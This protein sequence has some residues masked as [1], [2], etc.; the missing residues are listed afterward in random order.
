MSMKRHIAQF[1]LSLAIVL[2][3]SGSLV[4]LQPVGVYALDANQQAVCDAIGTGA[5]CNKGT[6][7]AN[8]LN[9]VIDT[10]INV[11]SVLVGVL[12]VI[13]VI[14]AGFK[15]VTSAEDSSK[16]TSAKNTLVYAIVGLVI[17]AL[18]QTIVKFVL[19]KVT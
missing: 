18:S 9:G 19:G 12:A 6:G 16:I 15:Y 10:I 11:L 3:I 8:K 5:N 7:G 1:F 4:A 13:M 14:I 17:V 2:G